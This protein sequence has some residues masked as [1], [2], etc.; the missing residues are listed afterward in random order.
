MCRNRRNASQ[1]SQPAC[2]LGPL[3]RF[4]GTGGV[5][6]GLARGEQSSRGEAVVRGFSKLRLPLRDCHT[7][8][9]IQ[10]CPSPGESHTCSPLLLKRLPGASTHAPEHPAGPLPGPPLLVPPT[11]QPGP[12]LPPP[13]TQGIFVVGTP[14][15]KGALPA[16]AYSVRVESMLDAQEPFC[17]AGIYQV[18]LPLSPWYGSV[19]LPSHQLPSQPGFN[20]NCGYGIPESSTSLPRLQGHL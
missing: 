11:P 12:G 19:A 4:G 1:S 15:R 5:W 8:V 16:L 2:T 7:G 10:G 13:P 3:R 6:E 20:S 17:R 9:V 14:G 18:S